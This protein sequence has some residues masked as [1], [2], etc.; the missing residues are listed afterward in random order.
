MSD[1]LSL[2]LAVVEGLSGVREIQV[3]RGRNSDLPADLA[4]ENLLDLTR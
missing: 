2:S 3:H 1:G 4:G